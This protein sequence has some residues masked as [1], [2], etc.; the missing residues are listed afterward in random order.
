MRLQN[1]TCVDWGQISTGEYTHL[2]L[3]QIITWD[4][5]I[6]YFL[7]KFYSSS[8]QIPRLD[9]Y[10]LLSP[11]KFRDYIIVHF[12]I[13]FNSISNKNLWIHDFAL[14]IQ[15]QFQHKSK[16][17]IMWLP[18]SRSSSNQNSRFYDYTLHYPVQALILKLGITQTT[19]RYSSIQC[20]LKTQDYAIMH[21]LI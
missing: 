12:L 6:T 2:G 11:V 13:L 1:Y 20:N 8:T 7:N 16:L 14:L 3:V 19:S 17:D 21:F 10:A 9:D 15:V 5:T 18:T 4:D